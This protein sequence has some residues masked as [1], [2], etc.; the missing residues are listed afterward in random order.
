[1]SRPGGQGGRGSQAPSLPSAS[2]YTRQ[3]IRTRIGVWQE[4]QGENGGLTRVSQNM[5]KERGPPEPSHSASA[6][7]KTLRAP[8][9]GYSQRGRLRYL[10]IVLTFSATECW[11]MTRNKP[12]RE[13]RK[14]LPPRTPP[15]SILQL[16]WFYSL[17]SPVLKG[18]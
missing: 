10:R 16:C 12:R 9:T 7:P 6:P 13:H 3:S 18:F 8:G 1:M 17:K 5:V 14:M 11:E 15:T 4:A 2:P